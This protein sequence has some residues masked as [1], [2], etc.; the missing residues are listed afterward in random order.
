MNIDKIKKEFIDFRM[1]MHHEMETGLR[2]DANTGE[3]IPAWFI[4]EFSINLNEEK[5]I[6]KSKFIF[7]PG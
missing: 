3:V 2:K 7:D 1:L 6:S 5:I 4:K